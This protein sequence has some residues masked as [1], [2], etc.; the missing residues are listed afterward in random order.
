VGFA[1][2]GGEG[3]HQCLA[4]FEVFWVGKDGLANTNN[5]ARLKVFLG[6]LRESL[7]CG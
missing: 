1:R 5:R 7:G 2:Y 6:F 3:I 4:N